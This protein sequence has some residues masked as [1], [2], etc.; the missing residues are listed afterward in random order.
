MIMLT[1]ICAL[2][3]G[4]PCESP[5]SS[6]E[7][8]VELT[9]MLGSEVPD[10][11]AD[12]ARKLGAMGS[13]AVTTV[14]LLIE[15][16]ASDDFTSEGERVW[17]IVC[18]SLGQMGP[19]AM[20]YLIR[21]LGNNDFRICQCA[22]VALHD[23]GPDVKDSDITL[24]AVEGLIAV[25]ELD[26]LKTRKSAMHGLT[27]LGSAAEPAVSVL[28]SALTHEDFHTQYFAEKALGAIGPD[29]AEAMPALS[30]RAINGVAIVRMY[31]VQAMGNIG[32][33]EMDITSMTALA[34]ATEDRCHPVRE[35]AVEALLK[36]KKEL[37]AEGRRMQG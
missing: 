11:R 3:I 4:T 10:V 24:Q 18:V 13:A 35:M 21:A 32:P 27:G 2:L 22:A 20:P 14:P 8:L 7:M 36:I 6:E 16:L 19:G 25:I 29:A 33:D 1:M 34:Q 17:A 31:A 9:E 15:C 37:E 5:Q 26:D 23:I 12:A 30:D 28:I